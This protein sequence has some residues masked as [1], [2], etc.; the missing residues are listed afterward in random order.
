MKIPCFTVGGNPSFMG[1]AVN[2]GQIELGG[3]ENARAIMIPAPSGD[4]CKQGVLAYADMDN[5]AE[6]SV[7]LVI[8][9]LAGKRG[10]WEIERQTGAR[11]LGE[12]LRWY[13]DHDF[14][15]GGPEYLIL[16]S[17]G[18]EIEARRWGKGIGSPTITIRNENGNI[19]IND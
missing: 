11:I 8:R 4:Y 12:N 5:V 1:I 9:C 7:L 17:P 2:G 13:Y 14:P 19:A 6:G 3:A 10:W 16:L 15:W 18:G